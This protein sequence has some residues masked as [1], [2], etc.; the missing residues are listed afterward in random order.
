MEWL[1]YGL[2]ANHIAAFAF[3]GFVVCNIGPRAIHYHGLY[4]AL[5]PDYPAGRKA[6]IPGII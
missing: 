2:A 5:Y 4:L 3:W 1:G 6:L